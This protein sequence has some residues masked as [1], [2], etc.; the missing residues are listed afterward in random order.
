MPVSLADLGSAFDLDQTPKFERN[1]TIRGGVLLFKYVHFRRREP[2]WIWPEV[3]FSNSAAFEQ[4]C[5]RNIKFY[6]NQAMPGYV[7]LLPMLSY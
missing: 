7:L 6:D 5:T 3:D 4:L 2:S 1:R